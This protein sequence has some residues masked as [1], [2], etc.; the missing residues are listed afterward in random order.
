M[1]MSLST[2][3]R[4]RYSSAGARHLDCHDRRNGE[5]PETAETQALLA[6]VVESSDDAIIAYSA[7]GVVLTW[8]RGAAKIFRYTVSE[9]IGKHVTHLVPPERREKAREVF[10]RVRCG[11][12]VPGYEGYGLRADGATIR[13]AVTAC[14]I[15][16]S[17]GA[18]TAVSTVARDV[19]ERRESQRIA[20]LLSAVVESSAD[21]VFSTGPDGC[22][23][24]WN[25]GA[26]ELFGYSG[27]EAIGRHVEAIALPAA[28]LRSQQMSGPPRRESDVELRRKDGS[29]VDVSLSVAHIRDAS[30]QVVGTS[31]I[32]RDIG[33]RLRTERR[34]RENETRFRR[35]FEN[36]PIGLSVTSPDRRFVQVNEA[37]CRMLGYSERELLATTWA[38]VT[39][40]EDL[41]L[42][43]RGLVGLTAGNQDTGVRDGVREGARD[44]VWDGVW[45]ME[46]RYIHSSGRTVW[47]RV[48]VSS[49]RDAA[50]APLYF[51]VHTEDIT[52]RKAADAALEESEERFR[53]MADSCPALMW[54][55]DSTGATRFLNRAYRE[56]CGTEHDDVEGVRWT[57]LLHPDDAEECTRNAWRSVRE[58]SRF[59]GE[60]RLRRADGEWRWFSS[61]AEPRFSATGAF[62]GHVGIALDITE[63]KRAE[64]LLKESSDRL[65][66]ATR[67]GTVGVWDY[68]VPD[69]SLV[70]DDQMF[71]LYG[72]TREAFGGALAAW[73]AGIHPDDRARCSRELEDAL[74]GVRDFDTEFQVVWSD[75]SVHNVRAIG[76]VQRDCTGRALRM[77]GTN[78][79]ITALK[80]AAEDLRRS[81][82]AL[83]EANA[84]ANEMA[85]EADRANAAKSRFLANMSHELRTPM[86][87]VI[88]MLQLLLR[89]RLTEEQEQYATVAER[90]GRTMLRLIDDILDLS[91]IEA[92]R[93]ALETMNFSPRSVVEEVVES[94]R[95]RAEE[96][97]L[98]LESDI[99]PD[100]PQQAGGDP[101]RL[102]QVLTNLAA[103]AVKFTSEGGVMLRVAREKDAVVDS[104]T[105]RL[106]FSVAD[107]GI[108][109][110]PEQIDRV[111]SPFVQADTSITREYGG[112]GL[113]L[114]ISKQLVEMMG[115]NIG[116]STEPGKG[117]T[118]WFTAAL[119]SAPNA[120]PV[121]TATQAPD[122][123]SPGVRTP[124]PRGNRRILVAEDNAVNRLVTLAQLKKLG[125][126]PISVN[127]GAE[128]VEA[129][130][131]ARFDLIL[132]DCQMP[133][134]DGFEAT[135]RIH[136]SIDPAIPIVALTADAMQ[137]D[138]ERC[139]VD[140]NDY[141]S[142][143]VSLNALEEMLARWLGKTVEQPATPEPAA[144]PPGPESCSFDESGL[145]R[146]LGGDRRIAG[147][148]L[149]GFFNH[150]PV[151]MARLRRELELAD[152]DGIF[153]EAHGIKGSASNVSATGL[154]ALARAV[155]EAGR[156]GRLDRCGEL[157]TQ[158]ETELTRFRNTVEAAG[159]L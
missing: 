128:A 14:P 17:T 42:S 154:Q 32:A 73:Q 118:F 125:Y 71:R 155:E 134:M 131:H 135:R 80:E 157:L 117:S 31:C 41:A 52:E 139:L 148:L 4:V 29:P 53:L 22:I 86:N 55:T 93:I 58:H 150:V 97:G 104:A 37:L 66:L 51:V 15:R 147:L 40:P 126:E 6:A 23:V 89:T 152:T 112:T 145:L 5:N 12:H 106:L 103:N 33:W 39:H 1:K 30:Q 158:A 138:R 25:R 34:L 45:D 108:G 67:A 49:V 16:N 63:R 123:D 132:M 74:D 36:A 3:K 26:E 98:K 119:E 115:G 68:N 124:P 151:Q 56:Y 78:W 44:R 20:G 21:A 88:G 85:A 8:N 92:G 10:E 96:K 130:R 62:L 2:D 127:N 72:T 109:I 114:A 113:G 70:W 100:V 142:K 153:A 95:I 24:T 61:A 9:A 79:D 28:V 137:E 7:E 144:P 156:E 35:I 110:P 91:R 116:V 111:F 50:G 133:V 81:N 90:S 43:D 46:K 13:L 146:R 60:N 129:V 84:K 99:E 83:A 64:T 107:T 94:L 136:G 120:A 122:G 38:Q 141:L 101:Y 77:I 105:G 27:K 65:M 143:P 140:M 76:Q 48:R 69:N 54:V 159:W 59:T 47:A 57:R 18:V 11:E 19:T 82:L 149:K 102:R 121:P 87:G 75:G